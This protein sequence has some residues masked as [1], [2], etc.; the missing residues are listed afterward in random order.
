MQFL[1]VFVEPEACGF[2]VEF[3]VAG[4]GVDLGADAG[5]MHADFDAGGDQRVGNIVEDADIGQP[6]AFEF[7]EGLLQGHQVGQRL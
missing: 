7:A 4:G 2:G 6:Q 3:V 1:G 5:D